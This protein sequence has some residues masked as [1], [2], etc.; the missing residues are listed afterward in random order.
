MLA[1]VVWQLILGNPLGKAAYVERKCN[2]VDNISLADLLSPDHSS[3]SHRGSFN[4]K[5]SRELVIALR[6]PWP[7][8]RIPLANSYSIDIFTHHPAS[9]GM[10]DVVVEREAGWVPS[11]GMSWPPLSAGPRCSPAFPRQKDLGRSWSISTPPALAPRLA[12]YRAKRCEKSFDRFLGKNADGELLSNPPNRRTSRR[13]RQFPINHC[14]YCVIPSL[15]YSCCP[16]VFP[17]ALLR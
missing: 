1:L 14:G 4:E 2:R 9:H 6:V 16:S 7:S 13:K 10:G 17:A 15:A 3:F 5:G 8:R 12:G 11:R